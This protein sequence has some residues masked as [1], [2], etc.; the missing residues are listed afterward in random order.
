MASLVDLV[1]HAQFVVRQRGL[2]APAVCEHLEAFVDQAFV[3]QLLEG[4]EHALGIGLVESLV[5]VV[6]VDPA[7]LAGY[8]GAPVFC[9]LQ[10]GCAAVLVEL[11]DAEL[12][13]FGAT[14]DL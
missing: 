5:V 2:A 11:V 14:R 6:E 10:H 1:V 7:R 3:V 4:P 12:L 9:V 13:D 8:I